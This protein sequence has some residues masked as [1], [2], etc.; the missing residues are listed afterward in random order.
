MAIFVSLIDY[1]VSFKVR[2]VVFGVDYLVL[3]K[4]RLVVFGVAP[5]VRI[6]TPTKDYVDVVIGRATGDA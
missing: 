4:V 3:F 2:L 1:L 5:N 6:V